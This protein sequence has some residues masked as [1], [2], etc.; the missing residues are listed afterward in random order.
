VADADG[1][2][3]KAALDILNGC[4]QEIYLHSKELQYLG[5]ETITAT[6][7]GTDQLMHYFELPST[8]QAVVGPVKLTTRNADQTFTARQMNGVQTKSHCM[9]YTEYFKTNGKNST[10]AYWVDRS[11]QTG[12]DRTRIRIY[13]PVNPFT[14]ETNYSVTLDVEKELPRYTAADCVGTVLIPL[15]HQ[16]AESLLVPLMKEKAAANPN[17][18]RRDNYPMYQAEAASARV[19]FGLADPQNPTID[20]SGGKP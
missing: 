6:L 7:G 14:G 3:V 4:V 5:R 1:A 11:A 17:A 19:M 13:T 10:V 18:V 2:K 20:K 15:P 16:Y 9:N 12:G 8:V